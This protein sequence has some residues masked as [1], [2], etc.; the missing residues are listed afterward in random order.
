MLRKEY[1]AGPKILVCPSSE[2]MTRYVTGID[3]TRMVK[4][5]NRNIKVVYR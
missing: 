1:T 4:Q 3:C 2:T 5:N